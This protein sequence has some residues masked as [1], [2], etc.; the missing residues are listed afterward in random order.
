MKI[1]S[2]SFKYPSLDNTEVTNGISCLDNS[3][4]YMTVNGVILSVLKARIFKFDSDFNSIWVLNFDGNK[5]ARN[6]IAL[7][8]S[9]SHLVVAMKSPTEC[10]LVKLDSSTNSIIEEIKVGTAT[11]CNS[12]TLS[13]DHSNIYLSGTV[14]ST[15]H[16]FKIGYDDFGTTP[17]TSIPVSLDSIYSIHSYTSSGQELM[18]ISGSLTSPTQS[19]SLLSAEYETATQQWTKN[20]GCPAL[21][22]LSGTNNAL[23]LQSDGKVI[24]YFL[25]TNPII[26]I[27]NLADG[28]FVGS[29]VPDFSQTGLEISGM[30]YST[31]F[32]KVF[33]VMKYN[34]GGYKIEYDPFTNTFSNAYR[35]K[36]ITPGWIIEAGGHTL[37]GSGIPSSTSVIAISRLA[38]NGIYEQNSDVSLKSKNDYFISS[39]GYSYSNDATSYLLTTP[40]SVTT[41]T[42]SMVSLVLSSPVPTDDFKEESDVIFGGGSHVLNITVNATGTIANFFPCSIDCCTTINSMIDPH[43]NGELLPVWVTLNTDSLSVDYI[44]PPSVG[45]QS[46]YFTGKSTVNGKEFLRN[47]QINVEAAPSSPS[48]SPSPSPLPSPLP[49][50]S[51]SSSACETLNCKSCSSSECTA[52]KEGYTLTTSKTCSKPSTTL[53]LKS[54]LVITGLVGGVLVSVV[55]GG[56]SGGTM[57]NMWTMF[58]QFQLFLVLPFL[59][60]ELPFEFVQTIRALET[61]ILNINLLDIKTVPIFEGLIGH[62]DYEN[63]YQEFRENDYDSGSAF[64]NCLD[65]IAYPIGFTILILILHPPL[66]IFCKTKN[67]SYRLKVY[68]CFTGLAYFKFYLRYYVENFLFL[69]LASVSEISRISEVLDH[70]TSFG[71]SVISVILLILFICLIPFLLFKVK[72]PHENKYVN[73]LFEGFKKN[74]FAQLYNF[75]FLLRRLLIVIVIVALRS[76]D[77]TLKLLVFA[78][79]QVLSLSFVVLVR[80]HDEKYQNIIEVMNEVSYLAIIMLIFIYQRYE[81]T[82]VET[83]LNNSII[84]NTMMV[85]VIS[86]VNLICQIAYSCYLKKRKIILPSS[87]KVKVKKSHQSVNMDKEKSEILDKTK[88]PLEDVGILTRHLPQSLKKSG[89]VSSQRIFIDSDDIIVFPLFKKTNFLIAN[90]HL[91]HHNKS[92]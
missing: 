28:A 76:T 47:V 62:L 68:S 12:L 4:V 60:A 55:A 9:G 36:E 33:V 14:S 42:S 1:K 6:A 7:H 41:G 31:S 81:S 19:Y 3:C 61:S 13:S 18:I 54:A 50:P 2:F 83:L 32:N 80:H 85:L 44:V 10:S 87:R 39:V 27:S 24:S 92:Q 88:M 29:Y 37:I 75:M 34:N 25:D 89:E 79:L 8:S 45:G 63:P 51:S 5:I 56:L 91:D 48:P 38:A 71:I 20:L 65:L 21:C 84:S 26:F 82:F 64:V 86:I 43:S 69:C 58:N 22:T 11:D 40:L 67:R 46:F 59:R 49:S 90:P 72:N 77:L 73:E 23:I 57:K 78:F 30:T 35:S 17:I 16:I 52:C 74:K 53:D 15:P 70:P 66:R